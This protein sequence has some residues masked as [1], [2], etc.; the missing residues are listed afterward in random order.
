MFQMYNSLTVYSS[1]LPY[2]A[3]KQFAHGFN[4][5]FFVT[6]AHWTSDKFKMELEKITQYSSIGPSPLAALPGANQWY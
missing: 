4:I 1:T 2:D 5:N 3:Y 6:H